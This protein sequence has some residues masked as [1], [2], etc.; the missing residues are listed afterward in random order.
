MLNVKIAGKNIERETQT[1]QQL[2]NLL[3]KYNLDKYLFSKEVVIAW[4]AVSHSDPVITLGTNHLENDNELLS[5]FLHEELHVYLGLNKE[6][7]E[8]AISQLKSIY[9]DVPN[10]S[11]GGA[12][13]EYSTYLHLIV[14]FLEYEELTKIIGMDEAIKTLLSNSKYKWVYEKVIKDYESIKKIIENSKL[15]L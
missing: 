3:S 11:K 13:T 12:K 8:N 6:N 9:P 2:E 15:P 7:T 5:V 14:C 10:E 4:L 1:K